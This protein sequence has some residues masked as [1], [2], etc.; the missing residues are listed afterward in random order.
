[1]WED[2]DDTHPH[3]WLSLNFTKQDT[4]G[5]GFQE[6]SSGNDSEGLENRS[7]EKEGR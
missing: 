7:N 1:M 4:S 5:F 6:N 3:K 2:T